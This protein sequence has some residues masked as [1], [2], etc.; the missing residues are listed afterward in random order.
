MDRVY[1]RFL[2]NT[3]GEAS[4]LERKSSLLRLQAMP[5]LPSSRY[6]LSFDVPY[7]RRTGDGTVS[8]ASGPV[9]CLLHFPPDYLRSVDP[10]LYLKVAFL[11]TPE[12]VHPNVSEGSICLGVDF[13]PGTPI[14]GV[15]W[16]VFEIITY[17][18]CTVDER[19]ALNSEACRLLRA[20]PELLGRLDRRPLFRSKSKWEVK[21]RTQ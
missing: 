14:T 10:K 13:E 5:P 15:V 19:N 7:L 3:Q 11:L 16:Q 2:E 1:Q 20:W 9:H 21:V 18:N 8:L 4:E 6:Q 12:L 17:R